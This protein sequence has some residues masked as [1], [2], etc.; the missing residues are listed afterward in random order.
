MHSN[1]AASAENMWMHS[2]GECTTKGADDQS[3]K[4]AAHAPNTDMGVR[5]QA[6]IKDQVRAS[7]PGHAQ[8]AHAPGI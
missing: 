1:F 6:I 3:Y 2:E 8:R 5:Q 7:A 4:R